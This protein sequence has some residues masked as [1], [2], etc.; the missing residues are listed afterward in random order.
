[1]RFFFS[2]FRCLCLFII[3]FRFRCTLL[4]RAPRTIEAWREASRLGRAAV[5]ASPPTGALA[6]GAI[7]AE[8]T[9]RHAKARTAPLLQSV[10]I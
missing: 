5:A 9:Q 8:L 10:R 7:A 1:M 3:F 6:V 2:R 4:S